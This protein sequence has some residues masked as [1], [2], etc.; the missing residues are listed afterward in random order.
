MKILKY[1]FLICYML[2][3][4]ATTFFLFT[5]NQFSSS[6]IG[7]VTI[8]GIKKDVGSFNK[9]DLLIAVK[10]KE[11]VKKNDEI[12]YYNTKQGKH[13]VTLERVEDVMKTNKN[14]YTYVIQDGLF[15]SSEYLIG[16][17]NHIT[18]IPFLGYCY[19]LFTSK[20]G[21]PVLIILP[22]TIAFIFFIRKYRGTM[23][24]EKNKN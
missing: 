1:I 15:L 23:K 12:I 10:K 11:Q 8:M 20:I 4:F 5:F 6:Q 21:Y 7:D 18:A 2:L 9:G 16:E 13:E 14:E 17:V 19:L 3:V 24:H 22:I